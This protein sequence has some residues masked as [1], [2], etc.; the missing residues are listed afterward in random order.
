M[1]GI[2]RHSGRQSARRPVQ[3]LLA[4][5]AGADLRH[6]GQDAYA[7]ALMRGMRRAR[8]P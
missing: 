6:R 2:S 1:Y 5:E 8:G 3:G 7:A 4:G